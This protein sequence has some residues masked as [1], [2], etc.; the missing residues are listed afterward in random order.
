MLVSKVNDCSLPVVCAIV[1]S[2]T[3][4]VAVCPV[5][6]LSFAALETKILELTVLV[7]LVALVSAFTLS[8]LV[9]PVGDPVVDSVVD[10]LLIHALLSGL[11][12]PAEKRQETTDI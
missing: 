4:D 9:D 1:E 10:P 8:A 3:E 11:D 5:S 7:S 12:K 2:S 6:G